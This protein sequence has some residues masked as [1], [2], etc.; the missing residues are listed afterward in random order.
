M[1]PLLP[2]RLPCTFSERHSCLYIASIGGLVSC[3][4]TSSYKLVELHV[5]I[6]DNP[7]PD[8]H[9]LAALNPTPSAQ[10]G[11]KGTHN[12]LTPKF[13]RVP[14]NSTSAEDLCMERNPDA[15]V[16]TVL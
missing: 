8:C 9:T 7:H 13:V 16:G 15:T 4:S 14:K 12:L 10:H 6:I 2:A 11:P 1:L 3:A 5:R